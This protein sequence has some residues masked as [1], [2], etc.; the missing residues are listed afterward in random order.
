MSWNDTHR[1]LESLSKADAPTPPTPP[2]FISDMIGNP[3]TAAEKLSKLSPTKR[4][5]IGAWLKS[6][7]YNVGSKRVKRFIEL[8]KNYQE[9]PRSKPEVA[10]P[11]VAKKTPQ[12][13]R[14]I[15]T[16]ARD[17]MLADKKDQA[18]MIEYLNPKDRAKALEV[19]SDGKN[20][21]QEHPLVK[22]ARHLLVPPGEGVH[23][24]EAGWVGQEPEPEPVTAKDKA[25]VAVRDV[26]TYGR[27]EGPGRRGTPRTTET[28][29]PVEKPARAKVD[30]LRPVSP[31]E[32][33]RKK[34]APQ[35]GGEKLGPTK[36]PILRAY[37]EG[38]YKPAR[39]TSTSKEPLPPGAI[40]RSTD[41]QGTER[42]EYGTKAD[43]ISR[44]RKLGVKGDPKRLK[45]GP[46]PGSLEQKRVEDWM[47]NPW[48][49]EVKAPR[50]K[51]SRKGSR[52]VS[53]PTPSAPTPSAPTPSA[54]TPSATAKPAKPAKP[55]PTPLKLPGRVPRS[56][57]PTTK[58][59][60]EDHDMKKGLNISVTRANTKVPLNSPISKD[61]NPSFRDQRKRESQYKIPPYPWVPG[62]QIFRRYANGVLDYKSACATVLECI[63]I[64]REGGTLNQFQKATLALI[65]PGMDNL[66]PKELAGTIVQ[67]SPEDITVIRLLVQSKT[68]EILNWNAGRGGNSVPMR[69]ITLS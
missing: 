40:R 34:S 46:A 20:F 16:I 3:S 47:K 12:I 43:L 38:R 44:A 60:L 33:R 58:S 62:N 36:S 5:A 35:R 18:G 57:L 28:S 2:E 45:G 21:S 48:T 54:P 24:E 51:R 41:A 50:P 17:I 32:P 26:S 15:Q 31:T 23:S 67:L 49:P 1:Y 39:S 42:I 55:A 14:T 63:G 61:R 10:S 29:T 30:I 25:P 65:I 56:A 22:R 19:L 8:Y 4:K 7:Y 27:K 69:S 9:P 53:A 66:L 37:I 64:L 11:A 68:R 52:K 13:R 6:K 59:L